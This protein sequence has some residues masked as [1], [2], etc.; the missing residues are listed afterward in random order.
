MLAARQ[1]IRQLGDRIDAVRLHDAEAAADSRLVD[2]F[3]V[4][5]SWVEPDEREW[6]AAH[7]APSKAV[8]IFA[9]EGEEGGALH[10]IVSHASVLPAEQAVK[11]CGSVLHLLGGQQLVHGDPQGAWC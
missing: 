2:D 6:Q 3:R 1:Q 11:F 8:A 10:Q 5:R 4:Y 9:A 7:L